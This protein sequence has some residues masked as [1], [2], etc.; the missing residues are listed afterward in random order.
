MID[1][2]K[3]TNIKFEGIDH[4]DYPDYCDAYISSADCDGIE[5]TSEELEELNEDGMFVYESLMDY[6]H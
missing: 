2:K 6:L 5:M 4:N 3:I 1:T